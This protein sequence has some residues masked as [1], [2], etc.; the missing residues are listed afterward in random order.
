MLSENFKEIIAYYI[1]K[2]K[3]EITLYPSEE[4]LWLLKGDIKNT[5]GNLGLHI[6]GNLKHFIGATLGNTGYVRQREKEF[7]DKHV[8][9]ESILK[10]LDEAK[11]IVA[12]VLP[13]LSDAD[14]QNIFP[15]E[16][17]GKDRTVHLVLI[18][19]VSHLNYHL[20]QVN[21]LRRM[22]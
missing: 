5:A 1:D 12:E 9:R 15:I 7:S 22:M 21:Y 2:L 20:G 18:Q 19:L 16:T 6:A 4:S 14:L 8:P 11:Q 17:F 3:E 13:K 10:E